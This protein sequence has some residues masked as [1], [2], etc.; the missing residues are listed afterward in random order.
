MAIDVHAHYIPPEFLAAVERESSR[1]GVGLDRGADGSVRLL[2]PGQATTRPVLPALLDLE[3][4][5]RDL[6][7]AGVHHQVLATW[8]DAVGYALPPEQ[9]ARWSR[10][11]NECLAETLRAPAARGRFSG[12][13]TVPLQDGAR[14]AAELEHA[15]HVLGLRGVQI[16]TNVLGRGLDAAGLDPFW[17]AAA[18]LRVPVILHPWHVAGEERMQR[19][20]MIRLVG[21]PAD[22]TLAAGAIIFGGIAE[23][24][25]ALEIVLV[26]AGGFYP[27]QAGRLQRAWTLAPAPKPARSALDHLR[28]FHYDTIAHLPEALRY[29][30]GLVGP[31][32]LLLGSDAPFDIGD[33]APVASVRAAALGGAAER[34]ILEENPARLFGVETSA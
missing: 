13:A 6:D 15:V 34:A 32:R 29:L 2:F 24:F 22:T 33:P 23:R 7:T 26:H 1:Y 12:V 28:W 16:G 11:F 30:V 21:Y 27:Y 31:E 3:R 5:V 10:R 17:E 14:A 20:G 18:A 4:R 19:H 8:M 9:G 25:P